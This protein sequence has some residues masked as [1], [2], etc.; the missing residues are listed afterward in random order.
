M[1]KCGI[2]SPFISFF[3][4]II[5]VWE[6]NAHSPICEFESGAGGMAKRKFTVYLAGPISGCNESQRDKWR[7]SVKEKYGKDLEFVDPTE[8]LKDSR[9]DSYDIVKADLQA[10]EEADGLL[11][12]MWKESIGSAIGIVRAYGAGKPVV[13]ADPN[14]INNRILNYYADNIQDTPLKAANVLLKLLRANAEWKVM[15][16]GERSDEPFER[17]KLMKAIRGAFREAECDDL[18]VPRRVL[19]QVIDQLDESNRGIKEQFATRD[20]N[21]KVVESLK[22]LEAD[23]DYEQAVKGVLTKWQG[24]GESQSSAPE[25]RSPRGGSSASAGGVSSAKSHSTIWGNTVN[26]LK[27]IPSEQARSVFKGILAIPGVSRITLGPFSGQE[28]RPDCRAFIERSGKSSALDGKLFDRGKKGTMQRF[29]VW[30]DEDV[31][32]ANILKRLITA[33]LQETDCWTD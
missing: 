15:K 22:A 18:V 31:D 17:Q 6:H 32:K 7:E 13:V 3:I 24:Y 5:N 25:I 29:Q 12:N 27:D 20:I 23:P 2:F 11:V 21:E 10:I 26:E 4:A 33:K 9:Y 8:A 28:E 19:E 1:K 16:S 14:H 30:M